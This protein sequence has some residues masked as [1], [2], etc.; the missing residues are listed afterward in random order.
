MSHKMAV[1]AEAPAPNAC[2][3]KDYMKL[4]CP[5]CLTDLPVNFSI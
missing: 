4:I 2:D 5:A 1:I 3:E